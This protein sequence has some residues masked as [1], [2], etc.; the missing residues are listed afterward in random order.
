ML[1][2]LYITEIC[3]PRRTETEYSSLFQVSKGNVI[4]CSTSIF[5]FNPNKLWG[6]WIVIR[7]FGDVL[8]KFYQK[9]LHYW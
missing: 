8:A 1:K 9:S 6:E 3:V 5:H 2:I 4:E 7:E